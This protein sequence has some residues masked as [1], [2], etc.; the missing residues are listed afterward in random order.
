M[1]VEDGIYIS[2]TQLRQVLD[3]CFVTI[4]PLAQVP[5]QARQEMCNYIVNV[6]I[7]VTNGTDYAPPTLNDI[8][9][10]VDESSG[11]CDTISTVKEEEK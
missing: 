9:I 6:A 4:V 7:G 3:R 10:S 11:V 5:P 1:I 2:L 8:K